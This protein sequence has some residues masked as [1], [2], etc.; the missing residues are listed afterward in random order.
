MMLHDRQ[1]YQWVHGKYYLAAFY[2]QAHHM[3]TG[4]GLDR[5][6]DYPADPNIFGMIFL[7]RSLSLEKLPD[8]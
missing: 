8:H 4:R 3:Q 2:Y 7:L 1:E 5:M 6:A